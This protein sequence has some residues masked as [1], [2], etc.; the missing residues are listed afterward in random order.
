MRQGQALVM[1]PQLMQAIKLL[2]LSNLELASFI[3]EELER[4]PLLE[5]VEDAPDARDHERA[6]R[7]R[8]RPATPSRPT[9]PRRVRDRS[10][11][12]RGGARH[13]TREQFRRRAGRP[14][15]RPR[16]RH[17]GPVGD[18]L[19]GRAA[20]GRGRGIEPRTLRR[21]LAVAARPSGGAAAARRHRPGRPAD[22][23][24]PHRCRRRGRLPV[25]DRSRPSPSGSASTPAR[26]ESVLAVVHGFDP[27]GVGARSLAECLTLQ[28]QGARPVRSRHGG[29]GRPPRTAGEARPRRAEAPLR[30]RRRGPRRH[31]GRDPPARP[32]ARPLLRRRAGPDR[33][34]GRLRAGGARRLL[35]DRPQHRRPAPRPGQPD[36]TARGSRAAPPATPTRASS[37]TACRPPTG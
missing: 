32:Q 34:A 24:Q 9:G 2:Q 30:R 31:G 21:G 33:R 16:G 28:L 20:F 25:R 29:A 11:R 26:V 13:R 27:T 19:D 5:R 17:D 15:H 4:N 7:T 35:A 37:T 36:P 8:R 14:E 12:A 22:R 18:L 3:E 6:A 10:R 23:P 1:T